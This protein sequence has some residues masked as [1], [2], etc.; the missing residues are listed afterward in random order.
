M[1][2]PKAVPMDQVRVFSDAQLSEEIMAVKKELFE[3]RLQKAT[4]QLNQPHLIRQRKHRLAQLLMVE[5]ERKQSTVIHS[6]P[7]TDMS[8]H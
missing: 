8:E 7:S 6:I 4:K 3:L 2:M 5:G 1:P